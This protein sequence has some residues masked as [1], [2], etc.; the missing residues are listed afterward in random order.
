MKPLY[1]KVIIY[2]IIVVLACGFAIE[3][4]SA[5]E[6]KSCS[7][8]NN[9]CQGTSRCNDKA[10]ACICTRQL[11]LQ[12]FMSSSRNS[13]LPKLAFSDYLVWKAN[14]SYLYLPGKDIFHP[15]RFI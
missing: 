13:Y 1:S 4:L 2:S 9:K 6:Q 7:C 10:R 11:N 14:E 12:L 3:L 15:P 5:V 8:C